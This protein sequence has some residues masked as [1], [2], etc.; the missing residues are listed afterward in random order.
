[1]AIVDLLEEAGLPPL[2]IAVA[3]E[4][5]ADRLVGEVL[6]EAIKVQEY[7]VGKADII[8]SL[9]GCSSV[10]FCLILHF[11]AEQSPLLAHHCEPLISGCNVAYI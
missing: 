1:M 11:K 2:C 5:D 7:L 6:A 9:R 10:Y 3:E 8:C 4:V